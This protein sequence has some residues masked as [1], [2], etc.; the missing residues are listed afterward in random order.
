MIDMDKMVE[1]V[2]KAVKDSHDMWLE[3]EE[4]EVFEM[5][6]DTAAAYAQAAIKAFCKEL[7]SIR[8]LKDRAHDLNMFH[9]IR[10]GFEAEKFAAELYTYLLEY[11]KDD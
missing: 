3:P 5:D 9:G 2:A 11:G 10:A 7:P 8:I 6:I 4:I 1:V